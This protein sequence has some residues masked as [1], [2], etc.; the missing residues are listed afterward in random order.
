MN[1]YPDFNMV[2]EEWSL[3]PIITSYWQRGKKN[4]DGYS[5]CLKTVMDFPLQDALVKALNDS[6]PNDYGSGL[7]KLYEAL[8][9]DFNY[10]DPNNILVMCDN[11][12]MDRIYMQLNQDVALTKMALT[13]ILTVRGIPQLFYGTEILMDNTG[14]HKNDGLIRSDFPGGW[15]EDTVNAFTGTGLKS[16]QVKAQSFLKQLLNW[17]KNNNVIAT[18]QTL[19]FAPFN[20][21]YVYFRY[22]KEKTIMV[23]LNKNSTDITIDTA[24]FAEILKN[25]STAVDIMNKNVYSLS[26]GISVSKKSALVLE[27]K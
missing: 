27:I 15:K 2:G 6:A 1:E 21:V 14:H 19:H 17:R 8:A 5:G 13:Y 16:E 18:G 7:I 22:N 4:P 24:R 26:A 11:H 12:D 23:I 25:R 20:G 9:C 10:A 3:N